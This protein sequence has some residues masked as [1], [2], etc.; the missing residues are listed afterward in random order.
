MPRKT[1]FSTGF[2]PVESTIPSAAESCA[3]PRQ[4]RP[5]Q[6]SAGDA[7]LANQSPLAGHKAQTWR[8]APVSKG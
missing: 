1:P 7:T 2:I 6:E 8:E 5:G 3:R 4:A